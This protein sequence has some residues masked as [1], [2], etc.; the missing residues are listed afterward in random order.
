VRPDVDGDQFCQ[1]DGTFITSLEELGQWLH[2]MAEVG[3]CRLPMDRSATEPRAV[4]LDQYSGVANQAGRS[5][6]P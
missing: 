4:L 1:P 5:L 6:L 3:A 2:E